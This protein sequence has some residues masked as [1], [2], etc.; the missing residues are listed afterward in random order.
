MGS[1]ERKFK[2]IICLEFHL[3]SISFVWHFICLAFHLYGMSFVWHF[4]CMACHLFGI[5][6][7]CPFYF[8][9]HF[10]CVSFYFVWHFICLKF[11]LFGI[12][13]YFISTVLDY[14]RSTLW[15]SYK[16]SSTT[17]SYSIIFALFQLGRK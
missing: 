4:F 13:R 11:H 12:S 14:V 3:A 9:W 5:S 16:M 10:I 2:F 7:V 17:A 15:Q 6:F 1:I 8:V